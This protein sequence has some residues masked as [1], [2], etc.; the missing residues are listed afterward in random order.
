MSVAN[1]GGAVWPCGHGGHGQRGSDGLPVCVMGMWSGLHLLNS[2]PIPF[3]TECF[4][5]G[6]YGVVGEVV[7]GVQVANVQSHFSQPISK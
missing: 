4:G 3:F 5:C 1:S 2:V 7:Q 6:T